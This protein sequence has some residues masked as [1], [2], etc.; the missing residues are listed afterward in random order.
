ARGGPGGTSA[1]IPVPDQIAEESGGGRV[2][3]PR[4]TIASSRPDDA[5]P[6][7]IVPAPKATIVSSRPNNT[8]PAVIK[9]AQIGQRLGYSIRLNYLGSVNE[10]RAPQVVRSWI[11]DK[12]LS[13]LEGLPGQESS[14]VPTVEVAVLL[15]KNQ[16]SSLSRQLRVIMEKADQ[17]LDTQSRDFFQSILSASA[18]IV[19]DPQSFAIKPETTLGDMGVMGEFLGDLPY[20]SVI[21]GKTE[22]DWYNMSAIEQDNFVR[23]LKSKIELYDQFDKDNKWAKFSGVDQGDWLYR[24]PLNAL[25]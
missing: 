14:E 16:L 11:A 1:A 10:V 15:T 19:N 2:P 22:T 23:V 18:Q 25:P 21:M 9:A 17:A 6:A 8:D 7:V 13:S 20:Q 3:D 24:V 12:D 4:G 5:A